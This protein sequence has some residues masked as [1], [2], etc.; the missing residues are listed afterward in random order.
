MNTSAQSNILVRKIIYLINIRRTRIMSRL[1]KILLNSRALMAVSLA[2]VL[3]G[4]AGF[5]LTGVIKSGDT[6]G[7]P[8]HAVVSDTQIAHIDD[9]TPYLPVN[10]DRKW[11]KL[12]YDLCVKNNLD[13]PTA[14]SFFDLESE[15]FNLKLV[16]SNKDK[17]GKTVSYD[18]GIAQINSVYE[19]EYKQFAVEYCVLDPSVRFDPLNP[20]HGIRAGLGGLVH[21]REYWKTRGIKDEKNLLLYSL[22][23]YNMGASKYLGYIKDS[24]KIS[25][26]YDRAIIAKRR[27]LEGE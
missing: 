9:S 21:F 25:R 13:F 11:Q 16:C 19:K 2:L 27:N 26:S 6:S 3:C 24:G 5:L 18:R 17:K 15:G 1:F 4:A 23:S 7:E 8:I 12:I 20:D 22:N 10:L 14:I